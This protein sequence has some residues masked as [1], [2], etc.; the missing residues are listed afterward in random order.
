[1][2]KIKTKAR[3]FLLT[4]ALVAMLVVAL[5]LSFTYQGVLLLLKNERTNADITELFKAQALI[6]Q[7]GLNGTSILLEAKDLGALEFRQKRNEF[8]LLEPANSL[9]KDYFKDEKSF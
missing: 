7:D 4:E 3:A 2:R 6:L 9:Y 5:M 8:Y 1:M